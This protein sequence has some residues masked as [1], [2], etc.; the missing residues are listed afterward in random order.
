MEMAL[1]LIKSNSSNSNKQDILKQLWSK[2]LIS[3]DESQLIQE[4][5]RDVF[6][7]PKWYEGYIVPTDKKDVAE[8]FCNYIKRESDFKKAKLARVVDVDEDIFDEAIY[9]DINYTNFGDETNHMPYN[10]FL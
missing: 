6:S 3:D 10:S 5:D 1:V 4:V 8:S 2:L 7:Y 9:R